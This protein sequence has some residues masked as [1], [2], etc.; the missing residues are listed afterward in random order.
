MIFQASGSLTLTAAAIRPDHGRLLQPGWLHIEN[1]RIVGC[2]QGLPHHLQPITY[3]GNLF[4]TPG[5]LDAH[6]HLDLDPGSRPDMME[7]V[8]L[9]AAYGLAGIR[10]GGDRCGRVLK[11]RPMIQD[12]LFLASPGVAMFAPGRYGAFLG[13]PVD[14]VEA[15]RQT[16]LEMARLG[17]DHVKVLASG[18]VSLK[19]F[20]V[21]GPPQFTSDELAALSRLA[22]SRGLPLMV[23]AN[24]PE[25]VSLAIKAEADSVEHGYFMG[26]ENL[27]KLADD[28]SAWIPTIQPLASLLSRETSPQR[29]DILART[30]DAQLEQLAAARAKG[31]RTV[32]GTDAGAPGLIIGPGL[33]QEMHWWRQAGYTTEEILWAATAGPAALMGRS[34]DLGRLVPGALAFVAGF[35]LASPISSGRPEPDLRQPPVFVGRPDLP[36]LLHPQGRLSQAL[37]ADR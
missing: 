26:M 14:G 35:H 34:R 33:Y 31:V 18:P 4:L 28:H 5:L 36:H 2:G 22:H 20:G 12:F 29:R 21:V 17:A 3:L 30:I 25:A 16:V 6:V 19:E 13:R 24:G 23:H 15:M 27:T 1:G 8:R 7:R 9:A 37:Q 32:L 11:Y 10:D